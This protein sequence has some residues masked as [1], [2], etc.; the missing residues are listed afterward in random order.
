MG[1]G[2]TCMICVCVHAHLSTIYM[3]VSVCDLPSATL[4]FRPLP[5]TMLVVVESDWI[6]DYRDSQTLWAREIINQG[7]AMATIYQSLHSSPQR[8]WYSITQ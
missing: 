3:C 6:S 8:A 1:M 4:V 7:V 5:Q 2:H